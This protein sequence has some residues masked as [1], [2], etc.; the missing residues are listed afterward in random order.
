MMNKKYYIWIII[1]VVFLIVLFF[2]WV[3]VSGLKTEIS[4]LKNDNEKLDANNNELQEKIIETS[5]DF[6]PLFLLYSNTGFK[7]PIRIITHGGYLNIEKNTIDVN[8]QEVNLKDIYGIED[9]VQFTK[10]R[11]PVIIDDS[12]AKNIN[13]KKIS[14]YNLSELKNYKIQGAYNL[15]TLGEWLDFL[16]NKVKLFIVDTTAVVSI[17]S[18]MNFLEIPKIIQKT[19][20]DHQAEDFAAIQFANPKFLDL[21]DFNKYKTS[22]NTLEVQK[23]YKFTFYTLNPAWYVTAE[24]FKEV[25]NA[26]AEIIPVNI[27]YATAEKDAER[28]PATILAGNKYIMVDY[29]PDFIKF[30]KQYNIPVYGQ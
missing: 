4:Q 7:E 22:W 9:D 1:L 21:V 29:V 20:S 30:C 27:T 6:K 15:L 17:P 19:I 5:K 10:D 24:K 28:Y 18:D 26:G 12:V 13:G 23:N 11:V 8:W 3:K 14:E 2:A 25:H 16:K